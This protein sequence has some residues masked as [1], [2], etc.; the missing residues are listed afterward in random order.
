MHTAAMR[1]DLCGHFS[2]SLGTTIDNYRAQEWCKLL[3]FCRGP[4]ALACLLA[5]SVFHAASATV[6]NSAVKINS[7]V[8][9]TAL[10]AVA[11]DRLHIA[12]AVTA[13]D[14]DKLLLS[15]RLRIEIASEQPQQRI[16]L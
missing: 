6:H 12:E 13:Q 9:S 10:E 2:S 7:D 14:R 5:A 4:F 3:P 8:S 1:A 11:S 16:G 15:P